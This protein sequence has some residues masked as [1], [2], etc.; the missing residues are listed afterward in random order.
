[1]VTPGAAAGEGL[2]IVEVATGTR[3]TVP[4]PR[5]PGGGGPSSVAWSPDGRRLA[6]TAPLRSGEEPPWELATVR[7]DGTHRRRLTRGRPG[8]D[9]DSADWS[10]DG[11]TIVYSRGQMVIEGIRPDGRGRRVLFGRRLR[12]IAR[13]PEW[14]PDG[15]RL[16]LATERSKLEVVVVRRD[17]A[18]P[19]TVGNGEVPVWLPNG[20]ALA[21]TP[22]GGPDSPAV[23]ELDGRRSTRRLPLPSASVLDWRRG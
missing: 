16:A 17:G 9:L 13:D 19:R 20:R 7:L 23:V 12:T 6:F 21:Y 18:N 4:L 3:R 11:R 1:M 2:A 14:S 10:P 5:R 15:R 22:A 8:E